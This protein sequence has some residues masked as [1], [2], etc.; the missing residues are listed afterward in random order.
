[1]AALICYLHDGG[2]DTTRYDRWTKPGSNGEDDFE[3]NMH[4]SWFF[5]KEELSRAQVRERICNIQKR[6][7]LQDVQQPLDWV[8]WKGWLAKP[9]PTHA[10]RLPCKHGTRGRFSPRCQ[11]EVSK[12]T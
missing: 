11:R 2:W 6:T 5:I 4:A 8:P 7:M 3:L 12:D 10:R 1:M 9:K